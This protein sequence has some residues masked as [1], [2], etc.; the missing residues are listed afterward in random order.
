MMVDNY[1]IPFGNPSIGQ[2]ERDLV[3]ET[4]NSGKITQG[5]KVKEFEEV[6]SKLFGYKHSIAMSNGTDADISA[7]FTLYNDGANIGDEIIAPACAFVAVGTSIE[8][9]GFRPRFVDIKRDSLNINTDLISSAINDRT[10]AIMAVHTMGKP[11]DMDAINVIAKKHNLRVI[12]DACEAHGASYKGKLTG[13]LGDMATFSFYAAH[14]I[15]SGEGGM[16]STNNSQLESLLKSSKDHGRKPGEIYFQHDLHGLNARMTD[17]HACIGLVSIDGFKERF[18][19]RRDNIDYLRKGLSE[20]SDLILV[21]MEEP[22]EICAPHAF[23]ITLKHPE[24]DYKKFYQY[25]E[26]SGIQ[27]KRNF[28]SMPTQHKRFSHLRHKLGEFPEAEY[29]GNNGLHF[30]IHEGVKKSDLN[31]AL[32]KIHSYFKDLK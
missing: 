12:E 31:Y 6:F 15:F 29:I 28:G 3:L 17:L 18:E 13:H 30:G 7:C 16:V 5:P 20:L 10:R 23:S 24:F 4:L 21:N 11:C 14:L 1:R 32:D 26:S 25:L 19:K 8:A 22:H 9:A 2:R 27:S